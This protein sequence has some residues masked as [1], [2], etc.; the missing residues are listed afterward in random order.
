[1]MGFRVG[2]DDVGALRRDTAELLGR[3]LELAE[4]VLAYAAE[5]DHPVAIGQLGVRDA[6]AFTG[7]DQMLL[8]SKRAAQPIDGRLRVTI[9]HSWNYACMLCQGGSSSSALVYSH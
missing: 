3:L 6:A 8:E 9:A 5:H 1:M 7:H 4:I 2:N